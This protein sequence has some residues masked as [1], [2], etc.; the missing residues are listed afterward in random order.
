VAN[1]VAGS[2]RGDVGARREGR[3]RGAGGRPRERAQRRA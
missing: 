3:R 1:R 2:Q